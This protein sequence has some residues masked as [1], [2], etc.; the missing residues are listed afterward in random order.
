MSNVTD[1]PALTV[2]LTGAEVIVGTGGT[3][4]IQTLSG[5]LVDES[6]ALSVATMDISHF[7]SSSWMVHGE[8]HGTR[9]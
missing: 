1:P 8:E 9:S 7:P 6:P 5:R 2:S 4:S 3:V